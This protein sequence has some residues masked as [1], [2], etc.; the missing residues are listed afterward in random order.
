MTEVTFAFERALRHTV[1][2]M[3]ATE[4]LATDRRAAIAA[5]H[6]ELEPVLGSPPTARTGVFAFT[7]FCLAFASASASCFVLP[8]WITFCSWPLPPQPERHELSPPFCVA[9]AS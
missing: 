5:H 7:A 6:P 2:D 9:V 8:T 1:V 4:L 3:N